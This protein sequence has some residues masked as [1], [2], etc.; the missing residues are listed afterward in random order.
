MRESDFSKFKC[1]GRYK[2]QKLEEN[3]KE[4]VI[5]FS[6]LF[7]LKNNKKNHKENAMNKKKFLNFVTPSLNNFFNLQYKNDWFIFYFLFF[8]NFIKKNIISNFIYS[9]Y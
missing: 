8:F 7:S 4:N 6:L 9:Q 2:E 3:S 1:L 5:L